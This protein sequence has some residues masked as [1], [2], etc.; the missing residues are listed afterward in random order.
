MPQ[1]LSCMP[2]GIRQERVIPKQKNYCETDSSSGE[3]EE[4][5]EPVEP[6]TTEVDALQEALTAND[7]RPANVEQQKL[8]AAQ[9][10]T[11]K[12]LPA[13]EAT[14]RATDTKAKLF[15][16]RLERIK[17]Q[18]VAPKRPEQIEEQR[19]KLPVYSEEQMIVES[20]NYNTVRKCSSDSSITIVSFKLAERFVLGSDHPR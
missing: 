11:N 15:W 9:D 19:R 3:D 8:H 6:T 2:K 18:H 13:K 10:K 17:G 16:E 20:I 1:K 12:A 5:A 14:T 7:V 4:E